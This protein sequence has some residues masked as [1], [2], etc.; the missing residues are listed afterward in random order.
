MRKYNG[1]E[2]LVRAIGHLYDNAIK[3]S[4][5]LKNGSEQQLELGKGVFFHSPSSTFFSKGLCLMLWKNMLE[6]L[7]QATETLPICSLLMTLMLLQEQEAL[8]E[9][10]DKPCT[11]YKMETSAEKA[12]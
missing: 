2:N 11:R 5:A 1:N 3:L 6:R 7:A 4:A 8:V 10:L 12:N 9:S